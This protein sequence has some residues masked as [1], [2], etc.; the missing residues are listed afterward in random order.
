MKRI[1]V[2]FGMAV[3]LLAGTWEVKVCAADGG[4]TE[5]FL[6]ELELDEI[7]ASFRELQE[8]GGVRFTDAVKKL[9]QGEVPMTGEGVRQ[10]LKDTLLSQVDGNRRTAV[11]IM[12]LLTVAGVVTNFISVFEKSQAASTGFYMMYLC[13]FTLLM[14]VFQMMQQITMD[15]LDRVITFMELLMPSYFLASVFASGSVAGAGFYEVTLG[16]ILIIQW[17]LKYAV[18][19]AVNLYVLFCM[20][21][22][23][24]KE[25]YLSKLAEILKTFVEWML[26]T[27]MAAALGFQ[28][29]QRLILPAVD[30]LKTAVLTKTAG[31]VP[32]IGNVFSGVTEVV[33]GS[34]VLIKNAVGAAGMIFLALLCLVPLLKLGFGAVFYRLLAAIAQPVSDRRMVDC[35]GSVGEGLGLLMKVLLMVGA[36]FFISIAMAAASIGS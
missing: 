1:A 33:L 19:P 10:L 34:A 15:A 30:S 32:G 5:E 31:A 8:N 28:T 2:I 24:T 29:I 9:I 21:N 3:L 26:K 18:M 36:L 25:D 7:D 13:L 6:D 4:L 23:L 35:V 16:V 14:Q 22:H 20:V 12:L 17:I 27:L 11:R